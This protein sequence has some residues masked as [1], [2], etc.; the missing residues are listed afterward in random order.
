MGIGG[1]FG[2]VSLLGFLLFL[3]GIG[4]AVASASQGRSARGGAILAVI[5]LV[6]GLLFSIVS[7]GLLIVEP[8]QVAVVW[9]TV[10]GELDIPRRPGT[11]IITPVIFQYR[12]YDTT[13]QEYTMS[14]ASTEGSRSG[15]DEV[16]AT[17]VDG[18][19]VGLDVTIFYSLNP[20]Q[21]NF[22]HTRWPNGVET[23]VRST[24]RTVIRDVI[25][26]FRAEAIY[27]EER[28]NM[29]VQV[30]ERMAVEF[31]TEGLLLNSVD[32]RGLSFSEQFRQSI[33]DKIAAEQ[34]AQQAAFIVQ[35]RQQEA[36]QARAV[37]AGERDASIS[38]AEGEAESIVLRARAEAQALQLVSE[39]IAANPALIQ[40]QY[41]QSLADNVTL[42]LIPSNS[43]FLFD[44][45]GLMDSAP[46]DGFTPPEVRDAIVPG[47]TPV[48]PAAGS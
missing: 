3:G 27:G 21:I 6:A 16:D 29:Q 47:T 38:R 37:A 35:Q 4:L 12:I 1:L 46:A 41:I 26:Q 44:L 34:R 18:Q 2:A 30:N 32:I 39:Q 33:E 14:A 24:S 8:R 43:P 15:N 20:E 22:L 28:G 7:Q 19:T 45:Q 5:G 13:Q 17:T 42:A 48:P 36:E 9:N 10:S 23:F 40:Y 31:E 25:S 11:H